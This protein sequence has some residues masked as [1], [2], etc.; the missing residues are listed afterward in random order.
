M[1]GPRG[2][3]FS[4]FRLSNVTP[5]AGGRH[6]CVQRPRGEIYGHQISVGNRD[7]SAKAAPR[8]LRA[9]ERPEGVSGRSSSRP[10]SNP[11]TVQ[12][13][14]SFFPLPPATP[15]FKA[16]LIK[17][18]IMPQQLT[19]GYINRRSLLI[20]SLTPCVAVKNLYFLN[21][22]RK[23]LENEESERNIHSGLTID[24]E[25]RCDERTICGFP[26]CVQYSGCHPAIL[27]NR[28]ELAGRHRD[29]AIL[30]IAGRTKERRRNFRGT[31]L[32]EF[33]AA[34]PSAFSFRRIRPYFP[35]ESRC[36]ASDSETLRSKRQPFS[37]F[38]KIMNVAN[39]T[40]TIIIDVKITK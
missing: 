2:T 31:G 34:V 11:R 23:S 21:S 16:S 17:D 20:N 28:G 30:I 8:L 24:G 15:R 29:C 6:E 1:N 9:F 40:T 37:D 18:A 36:A 35:S 27:S 22:R 12:L 25:S 32:R 5:E 13:I 26:I 7:S 14:S 19:A 10:K 33:N 39:N 3:A 4:V 38:H